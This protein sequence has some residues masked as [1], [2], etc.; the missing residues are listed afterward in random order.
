MKRER[1]MCECEN[2]ECK[3]ER[4]FVYSSKLDKIY[5]YK[6]YCKQCTLTKRNK[7]Q[8][9]APRKYKIV[10]MFTVIDSN[11]KAYIFG[12]LWADGHLLNQERK[13]G[14][15]IKGL[16]FCISWKDNEIADF[17]VKVF[18]G[19][20][21]KNSVIDKRSN[22]QFE[23][24]VWELNSKEVY[25]NFINLNFRKNLDFISDKYISH[26]VRGLIDGD[27]SFRIRK[28]KYL[29]I[30]IASELDQD[31]SFIKNI[32]EIK[33]CAI[34]KMT[35]K[36]GN[37]SAFF[38]TGQNKDKIEFLKWVYTDYEESFYFKRKF[39]IIKNEILYSNS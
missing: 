36:N 12:F 7:T 25:N 28:Q 21:K 13:N 6:K 9:F 4:Y 26:F 39:D 33:K 23:Q 17:F 14:T 30:K 20:K 34:Y 22:K 27:G 16:K 8:N 18:G 35:G 37:G 38:I 3:K 24:C 2:I 11:D 29:E 19:R 5:G 31:W 32:K 15:P 1:K 10:D